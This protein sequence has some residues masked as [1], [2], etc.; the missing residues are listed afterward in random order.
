M[1]DEE[2]PSKHQNYDICQRLED[3]KDA[4][5]IQCAKGNYDS[6]EYMLGMANA[7]L[8]VECI[9]L[10]PYGADPKFLSIK[11][12]SKPKRRKP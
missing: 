3:F 2:Y 6:S 1:S 7:F 8:L 5:K 11:Q 12:V 9:L 10:K 4:M